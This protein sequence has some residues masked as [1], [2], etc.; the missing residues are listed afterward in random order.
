MAHFNV[1]SQHF[2]GETEKNHPKHQPRQKT[3]GLRIELGTPEYEARES[4]TRYSALSV[5]LRFSN[6]KFARVS[7]IT[8]RATSATHFYFTLTIYDK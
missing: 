6:E 3:S 1:Q 4:A 7:C 2:P 8:M 5:P